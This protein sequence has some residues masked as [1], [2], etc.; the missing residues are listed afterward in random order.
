MMIQMLDSI[1]LHVMHL[2]LVVATNA[3][4]RIGLLS[5]CDSDDLR[6]FYRALRKKKSEIE[7]AARRLQQAR[8]RSCSRLV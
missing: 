5:I 2:L 6:C 3:V 7:T 8:D 1:L 4:E